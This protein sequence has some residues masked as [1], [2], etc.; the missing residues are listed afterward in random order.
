MTCGEVGDGDS[1]LET[2]GVTVVLEGA[3]VE[4]VISELV[5]TGVYQ[6]GA[7]RH[8]EASAM[9]SRLKHPISPLRLIT[10]QQLPFTSV[11][12]SSVSDRWPATGH[13]KCVILLCVPEH[14]CC[15]TQ[16]TFC[17][18]STATPCRPKSSQLSEIVSPSCDDEDEDDDED[19]EDS[20]CAYLIC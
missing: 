6:S 7:G 16:N 1:S 17:L 5:L 3:G 12:S 9:L 11:E 14:G 10:A 2:R 19:E 4:L 15:A 13:A 20:D 18:P 8:C